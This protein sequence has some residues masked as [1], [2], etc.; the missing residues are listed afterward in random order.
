MDLKVVVVK[1]Q[2]KVG[3]GYLVYSVCC[4]LFCLLQNLHFIGIPSPKWGED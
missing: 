3:L 1:S 4:H 2:N